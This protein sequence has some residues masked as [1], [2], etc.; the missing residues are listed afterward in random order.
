MVAEILAPAGSLESLKAAVR[1]GANAV[2][3]GGKAF[4][5][6]RNASNF[7]DEELKKAVEY[8]HARNVKVYQ[9]LNTIVSD[10]EIETA[11]E[12]IKCACEANIDALILQ[13]IGLAAM[14]RRVSS[15][16]PMHASTQMSVQSIEGIRI[17]EKLGFT[18][19]VLPR[20]LS[21]KEIK[22]ISSQTDMELEYFVHGALCMCVSGQCLMSSVL[23]G[24][25]GNRGLCAQPCRLP[26]G[27]NSKGGNNLSL[28]DL[29]LVD[30]L[31]RL[32]RAGVCSFKIEGRMKRPEYVAAAVTACKNSLNNIEDDEINESLKA[33]FSRSGFTKGYF[34]GRLGKEMFGTRRKEDVEGAAGVLSGLQRL[35]DKETALLSVDFSLVFKENEPMKLKA[36]C[37]DFSAE[38]ISEKTPEKALNKPL[39]REELAQ[40]ISKCG[41]TQFYARKVD[42]DFTEG[43]N[44]SAGALNEL[45]RNALS[46]LEE[47]IAKRKAIEVLTFE[48]NNAQH[49]AKNIE[50]HARFFKE[51]Q[52][53][54]KLK[55]ISRAILPIEVSPE[56]VE[57]LN[58]KGIETAI[59]IPAPVFLNADNYIEKLKDLKSRGASLAWVCTL[60]GI[61]IAEKAGFDFASGF[62]MNVFNSLSLDEIKN[63]GAR[64]TLLSCEINL[65]DAAR[66]S[67]EIPRGIMT[68]GRIP[69]MLTRNC[70]VKNKL[71]CAECGAKSELV[72]RMGVRFPVV[73][74]NGASFI[75]NSRPIWLADKKSELRNLDFSLLY[76]T[77]EE[78]TE[79]E[80]VIDAY[81]N[82][83]KH[84][85]EFTRGLYFKNVL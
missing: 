3:L 50:L 73:C 51:E 85:G 70:P 17:L 14:V 83:E 38:A 30:E 20:E 74:K 18:R 23:G 54:E 25:S 75:L 53:P 1:C 68:Y 77:N 37:E 40:R 80:R 2:Y 11:Y 35:Y 27:V 66:L 31:R 55:N 32:E 41:G 67:G 72:D 49:K 12:A 82:N 45:R 24:R 57:K 4:N 46:A 58:K 43:L 71:T 21:E 56:T 84:E 76:F 28:K 44:V 22:A 78:K 26:F 8:C 7:S 42:I 5:A 34:E 60:D 36:V 19:A 39:S 62:G 79:C 52:I 10:G 6:R 47:G 59:E 63:L 48:N 61:G 9:T 69:L 33:V 65:S 15:S 16:M 81:N 13:D 64:D 29:S